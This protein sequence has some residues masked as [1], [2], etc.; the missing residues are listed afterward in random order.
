MGI[1]KHNID[2]EIEENGIFQ[3]E[4]TYNSNSVFLKVLAEIIWPI[5]LIILE[6]EYSELTILN[7]LAGTLSKDYITDYL[8]NDL[9]LASIHGFLKI[10]YLI[11]C[12]LKTMTLKSL[13]DKPNF[14]IVILNLAQ[15]HSSNHHICIFRYYLLVGMQR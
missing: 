6:F 3:L 1:F 14:I 15:F 7:Y 4:Y 2:I 11:S 8:A 5:P 13:N 9:L 12:I 10:S